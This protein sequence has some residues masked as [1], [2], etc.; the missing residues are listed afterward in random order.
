MTTF[1]RPWHALAGVAASAAALVVAF[2]MAPA[3]LA[4]TRA[5]TDLASEGRLIATFRSAF[6]GY[7]SAGNAGFDSDLQRIVDYWFRYH[8]AKAVLG[9]A[10][11]AV[12]IVLAVLSWQAFL[13]VGGL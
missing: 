13:R 6:V 8:V 2:V 12:F 5:T 3:P 9:G 7:W 11:L 4:S 10:L 1:L